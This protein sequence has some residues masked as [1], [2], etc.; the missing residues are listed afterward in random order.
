MVSIANITMYYIHIL[1]LCSKRKSEL[2]Q[3]YLNTTPYAQELRYRVFD[4]TCGP[5]KLIPTSTLPPPTRAR[6]RPAYSLNKNVNE[7]KVIIK[8][9]LLVPSLMLA[10]LRLVF[11][12]PACLLRGRGR[13]GGGEA[14]EGEGGGELVQRLFDDERRGQIASFNSVFGR[15]R[16]LHSLG[17][18]KKI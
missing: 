15:A 16:S 10:T 8:S 9:K 4:L 7:Q 2:W 11:Q 5:V 12:A 18:S 17:G 6:E 13:G 3:I 14:G 1:S